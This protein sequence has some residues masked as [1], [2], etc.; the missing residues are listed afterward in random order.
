MVKIIA[1]SHDF[2][3]IAANYNPPAPAAGYGKLYQRVDGNFY[4]MNVTGPELPMMDGGRWAKP[5]CKAATTVNITLSGAQTIDGVSCVAG[6]RVL[7]KNQGTNSQNGIYLVQTGTWTRAPDASTAPFLAGA[8]VNVD[9]GTQGGRLYRTFF[10][11]TDTV[12]T[13]GCD[14][15]YVVDQLSGS[16]LYAGATHAANHAA[17][18]SDPTSLAASQISSGNLDVA[19]IG[20]SPLGVATYLKSGA[21]SG[22]ASWAN[23]NTVKTDLAIGASDLNATG[24]TTTNYLRGDST[25]ANPL[26]TN[27]QFMS[28]TSA[29]AASM[30]NTTF[31]TLGSWSSDG[32][33]TGSFI[34]GVPAGAF[35]FNLAGVYQIIASGNVS[36]GGATNP[37]RR[38]VAIFKGAT[39]MIRF[40]T[41]AGAVSGSNPWSGQVSYVMRMAASDTF[42]IQLWQNSGSTITAGTS[43]GHSCQIIK[44]SD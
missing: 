43:P 10:K 11:A 38:I 22:S 17:G 1:G 42:T 2:G 40:D 30:T 24:R 23:V 27:S 41:G 8:A 19:R 35:T 37:T 7:V 14:W 3:L 44:L 21:T 33:G 36:S 5:N 18:G 12:G 4:K 31:T 26:G 25:W 6:D 39:E 29:H 13:T 16:L 28:F 32:T 34:S 9:Q 15:W 20:T